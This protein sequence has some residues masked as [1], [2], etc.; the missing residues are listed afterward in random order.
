MSPLW[1]LDL[2]DRKLKNP[3]YRDFSPLDYNSLLKVKD[4]C[5]GEISK[6]KTVLLVAS[7]D[8]IATTT[9][10]Y[11]KLGQGGRL[12]FKRSK[13]QVPLRLVLSRFIPVSGLSVV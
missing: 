1:N 13:V 5:A 3:T 2:E 7:H 8:K 10:S 6:K 4:H 12:E 11:W 9:S